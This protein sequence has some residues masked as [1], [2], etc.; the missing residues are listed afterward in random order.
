MNSGLKRPWVGNKGPRDN[1]RHVGAKAL[2]WGLATG[3]HQEQE[4]RVTP[5]VTHQHRTPR[6]GCPRF[7][8]TCEVSGT[9]DSGRSQKA[10]SRTSYSAG[11]GGEGPGDEVI[12]RP[13]GSPVLLPNRTACPP[14]PTVTREQ[15][16]HEEEEFPWPH[17][18]R[19]RA[20]QGDRTNAHTPLCC[21]ARALL[22]HSP[23]CRLPGGCVTPYLCRCL[24]AV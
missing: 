10:C 5:M 18:C 3:F 22:P 9:D 11:G 21:R 20:G 6:L 12:D 17:A 23:P 13:P 1:H 14:S 19:V 8:L 2:P 24:D 7:P 4:R 15:G 16:P